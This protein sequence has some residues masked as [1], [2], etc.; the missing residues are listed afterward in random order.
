MFAVLVVR[1]MF[2]C[3]LQ[4]SC[5][6]FCALRIAFGSFAAFGGFDFIASLHCLH[7][8]SD[9]NIHQAPLP[10][11]HEGLGWID[12]LGWLDTPILDWIFG[13][14][15]KTPFTKDYGLLLG[16][17]QLPVATVLYPGLIRLPFFDRQAGEHPFGDQQTSVGA[18]RCG[19]FHLWIYIMFLSHI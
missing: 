13:K 12:P 3:S 10:Q 5:F 15:L 18:K 7:R 1:L 4:A 14:D 2:W 8:K 6:G 9:G 19:L 17:H 16:A 11:R